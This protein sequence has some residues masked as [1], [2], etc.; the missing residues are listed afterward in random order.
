MDGANAAVYRDDQGSWRWRA[1]DSDGAVVAVGPPFARRR[2]AERALK[3]AERVFAQ[4]RDV[5]CD[6]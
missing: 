2:D 1:I 4:A 3:V 6:E 5:D